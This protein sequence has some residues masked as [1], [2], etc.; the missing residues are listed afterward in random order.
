M[1]GDL[2]QTKGTC[3]FKQSQQASKKQHLVTGKLWNLLLQAAVEFG[4]PKKIRHNI[5]KK[6][7]NGYWWILS[8][9]YPDNF[10]G[11]NELHI[12]Y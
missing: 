10:E 11:L 8:N 7:V 9:Y 12:G 6:V 4:F 5:E 3:S 2:R 1:E